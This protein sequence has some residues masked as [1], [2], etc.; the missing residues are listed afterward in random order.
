MGVSGGV[1]SM[2]LLHL[3]VEAG[4]RRLVVCHLNHGL[5]GRESGGDARFVRRVARSLGL[6]C[7]VARVPVAARARKERRSIETQAR[8][9]RWAFFLRAAEKHGAHR[10]FL[11]HHRDDQAETVLANLARGTGV[12]GLGGMRALTQ[13]GRT[14]GSSFVMSGS[15]TLVRPLLGFSRQELEDWA[16]QRS[17]A[18]RD[19]ATNTEPV[20]TRNRLRHE[21]LPLLGDILRRD[22][23]PALARLASLAA[24]EAE[25]MESMALRE[26][27]R[28]RDASGALSVPGLA[29]LPEAAQRHVIRLWLEAHPVPGIE[30]ADVEAVRALLRILPGGPGK[31]NLP[32]GRHVRRKAKKLWIE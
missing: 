17:L 32:R 2:V 7:E 9:E 4:Y 11:A 13:I 6:P 31:I 12:R 28:W 5:R 18:W 30:Q 21:G 20:A 8:E 14:P 3:L 23:R 22:I 29:A 26:L 19:D 27:E 16:R 1:D 10:V 15:F 24:A 25:W